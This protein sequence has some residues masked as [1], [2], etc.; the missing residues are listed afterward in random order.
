MYTLSHNSLVLI[1]YKCIFKYIKYNPDIS[2]A[3]IPYCSGHLQ[4]QDSEK[5]CINVVL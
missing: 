5:Y 3:F 1:L 4:G 2:I